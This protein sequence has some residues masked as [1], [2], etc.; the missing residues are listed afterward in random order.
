MAKI[1]KNFPR[2]FSQA[3]TEAGYI[4]GNRKPLLNLGDFAKKCDM[5]STVVG[6]YTHGRYV[7]TM[8]RLE[9][10]ARELGKPV[11]YFFGNGKRVLTNEMNTS[12]QRAFMAVKSPISQVADDIEKA[13]NTKTFKAKLGRWKLVELDSNQ[14][15][16]I[17]VLSSDEENGIMVI[18]IED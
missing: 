7:P 2:L 1:S 4:S 6:H 16:D 9:I 15:T 11:S 5:H 17:S 3:L 18:K 12:A 10:I 13:L 14:M 8:P